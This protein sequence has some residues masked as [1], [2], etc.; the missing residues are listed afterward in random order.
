MLVLGGR[1]MIILLEQMGNFVKLN[2]VPS[3][4]ICGA[5]PPPTPL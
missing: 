5:V 3:L 1:L 2:V 4:N